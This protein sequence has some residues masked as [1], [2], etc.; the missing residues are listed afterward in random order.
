MRLAVGVLLGGLLQGTPAPERSDT[1]TVAVLPLELEGDLGAASLEQLE[2]GIA[3]GLARGDFEVLEAGEIPGGVAAE[4]PCADADCR[5]DRARVLEAAYLVESSVVADADR[6]YAITLRLI[7]G[8]TGREAAQSAETCD[9]C[10][11]TEVRTLVEDQ[12]SALRRKLQDLISGPPALVVTSTPDGALVSVDGELVGRTPMRRE[13]RE[14]EH[15]ARVEVEGYVAQERPFLAVEGVEETL[16]FTLEPVPRSKLGLRPWGWVGLGVGLPTLAAGATFLVL[17]ERPAPGDR[18]AGEN[19]NA[20]GDCRF[21]YNSL[22]PGIALTV[23]G[24]VLTTAAI[25]ILISTARRRKQRSTRRRRFTP[26]RMA[27]VVHR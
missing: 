22:T 26:W 16:S 19:V 23:T 6:N 20:S 14:G 3:D 24:A 13:L 21:R 11:L 15:I 17:D 12:A 4:P 8:A 7:D 1:P 27:G 10:G 25:A 5:V 2:Q 9:V 18:C